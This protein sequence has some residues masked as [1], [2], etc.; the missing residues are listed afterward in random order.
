MANIKYEIIKNIGVLTE[1]SKGFTKELYLV[2]WNNRE[3]N[4]I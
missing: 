3:P 2:S 1:F 4:M